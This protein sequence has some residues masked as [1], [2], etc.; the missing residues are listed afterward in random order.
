MDPLVR[1][2]ELQAAG[3]SFVMVTV[4]AARGSAPRHAGAKL[5][6][7]PDGA[8][9]GTIGGGA[10]EHAVLTR[11]PEWMGLGEP[12]L[13]TYD[14]G[15]DL[16]MACGGAVDLLIEP[17]GVRPRLVLYGAGHVAIQ[18]SAVASRAGFRVAVVDDRVEWANRE[19]HPHAD[20]VV[21]AP[22]DG[23]SDVV[24]LGPTDYV[25]VVTRGH[26]SDF[27]MASCALRAR[28]R[29]VGVIGSRRKAVALRQHL[30][31][32][33]HPAELIDTVRTPVGVDI[34]A[35]TPAE[36]AVSVVAE[37]IAVRRKGGA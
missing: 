20:D 34:G 22:L 10:V 15:R 27:E 8:F 12:A 16:G 6:M 4:V 18:I 29:Y 36:I 3:R 21:V 24:G 32:D 2:A 9:C 23:A 25:V 33:G 7:E 35:E 26:A 1:A 17:M 30:A 14:L 5:V 37:L 11:R 31:A 13:V 19:Q 28:P